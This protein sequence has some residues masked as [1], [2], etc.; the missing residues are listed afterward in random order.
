[1]WRRHFLYSWT[2]RHSAHRKTHTRPCCSLNLAAVVKL[3]CP[4]RYWKLPKKRHLLF[5]LRCVVNTRYCNHHFSFFHGKLT[6]DLMQFRRFSLQN[7]QNKCLF[8]IKLTSSSPLITLICSM[9]I[10]MTALSVLLETNH[11]TGNTWSWT[12]YWW[13]GTITSNVIRWKPGS[14]A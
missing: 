13:L 4:N 7:D 8:V 5:V 3:S 11:A 9:K 14:A 10:W 1:M 2:C 6:E 12:S